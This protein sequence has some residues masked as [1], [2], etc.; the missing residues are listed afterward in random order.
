MSEDFNWDSAATKLKKAQRAEAKHQAEGERARASQKAAAA[1][2]A[3]SP[4]RTDAQIM[5]AQAKHGA[6]EGEL[7]GE[8][9]KVGRPAEVKGKTSVAKSRPT[10]DVNA[11][12][13]VLTE[14]K[15]V[16]AASPAAAPKA[17]APKVPQR[18]FKGLEI[19][20]GDT[21]VFDFEKAPAAK[22]YKSIVTSDA[23]T[24]VPTVRHEPTLAPKAKANLAAAPAPKIE[25]PKVPAKIGDIPKLA[26][27]EQG[28]ME[29]KPVEP[30]LDRR[31]N[32]AER[33]PGGTPPEGMAERRAPTDIGGGKT[34]DVKG[35]VEAPAAAAPKAADPYEAMRAQNRTTAHIAPSAEPEVADAMRSANQLGRRVGAEVPSL[36][37]R[38]GQWMG[39]ATKEGLI[40]FGKGIISPITEPIQ[41]FRAGSAER[42]AGRLAANSA[43]ASAKTL[44]E[45]V[46]ARS[47]QIAMGARTA[48]AT[49]MLGG[50]LAIGGAKFVGEGLAAGAVW[51]LGAAGEEA[52]QHSAV[53]LHK[54]VTSGAKQG[55][56]VTTNEPSIWKMA[57]GGGTGIKVEDPSQAKDSSGTSLSDRRRARG[58]AKNQALRSKGPQPVKQEALNEDDYERLKK[59]AGRS[60]I[61]GSSAV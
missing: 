56:K 29:G 58:E 50:R 57:I 8:A 55:L 3:K 4:K 53:D 30:V 23:P 49:G 36:G 24:E 28:S 47:G 34:I 26:M 11:D 5:K 46:A 14:A 43:S 38:A 10:V 61:K 32:W 42:A 19:P 45:R 37:K 9:E 35:T 22:S 6:G 17:A 44:G 2:A 1:K 41:A 15:P 39:K 18:A 12:T 54:L 59:V 20:Q 33:K 40:K 25:T 13:K 52:R 31:G 16:H 7:P 27:R 51:G 48:A 21:K 60:V